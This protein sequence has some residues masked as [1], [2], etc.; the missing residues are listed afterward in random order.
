MS[1][2]AGDLDDLLYFGDS[3]RS[4]EKGQRFVKVFKPSATNPLALTAFEVVSTLE[5]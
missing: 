3:S 2:V 4:S 1:G 5:T